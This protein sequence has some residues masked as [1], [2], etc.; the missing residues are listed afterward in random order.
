MSLPDVDQPQSFDDDLWDAVGD[1]MRRAL[2]DL[3]LSSGPSSATRLSGQV[4]V[5][6][7]AV[8]K[9]LAVLERVGLVRA[10]QEG[11]ERKFAVNAEQLARA[12]SQL[13]HVGR[14]W[15]ERLGRI[16]QLAE[17]VHRSRQS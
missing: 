4:P 12:T 15:D 5:T 16:K 8:A 7:Q 11:R 14:R 9:H 6:R 3:M 1:P 17:E 2:V 13:H 10:H